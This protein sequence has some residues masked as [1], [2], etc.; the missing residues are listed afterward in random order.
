MPYKVLFFECLECGAQHDS[1]SGAEQ[2]EWQHDYAKEQ[3][4]GTL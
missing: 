2:C 1:W 3:A 4:N